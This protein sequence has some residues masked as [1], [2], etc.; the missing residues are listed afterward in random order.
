MAARTILI[1][2]DEADFVRT[3]RIDLVRQGYK[4]IT[5]GDGEEGMDCA[6]RDHPDLI[7]VDV[8]MP[9]VDG[10]TFVRKLKKDTALATI[11]VIVLT[12]Y[13]PLKEIFLVEGICDYFIKSTDTKQ[14]H[15]II[16]KR[17]EGSS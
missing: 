12:S 7:I 13:E 17:L 6:V 14:L 9:K 1:I 10:Y 16:R 4:V 5:A 2:D 8:K 3:M 11:P 15:E